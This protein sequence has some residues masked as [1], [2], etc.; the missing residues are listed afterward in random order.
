[1]FYCALDCEYHSVVS[2]GLFTCG[3][4]STLLTFPLLSAS[5]KGNLLLNRFVYIPLDGNLMFIMS[6]LSL[7]HSYFISWK[8]KLP[9]LVYWPQHVVNM[10]F[11]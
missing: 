10:Q 7:Y 5:N 1:M 2:A 4:C 3:Q 11:E 9:S 6:E 8:I